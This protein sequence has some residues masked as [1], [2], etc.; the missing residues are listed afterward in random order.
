MNII[1]NFP[2]LWIELE[3]LQCL[4]I[5]YTVLNPCHKLQLTLNLLSWTVQFCLRYRPL[6]PRMTMIKSLLQRLHCLLELKLLQIHCQFHHPASGH[7]SRSYAPCG[8]GMSCSGDHACSASSR[9]IQKARIL[10]SPLPCT[11][12]LTFTPRHLLL[13]V[14]KTSKGWKLPQSRVLNASM[15]IYIH[16]PSGMLCAVLRYWPPGSLEQ[17]VNESFTACVL[18]NLGDAVTMPP[19]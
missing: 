15:H 1:S 16:M 4:Q 5:W 19:T 11:D 3:P 18:F 12:Y 2:V 14:P 13:S 17:G 7:K 6:W 8:D 10:L 9:R